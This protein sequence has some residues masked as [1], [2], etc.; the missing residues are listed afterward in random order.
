MRGHIVRRYKN[1]Y[2][3]VLNLGIDSSN[4]KYKQ[5]WISIKGTKKDAEKRLAELLH[6]IDT[7]TFIE[8]RK[9][10]L[11]EFLQRWL[12]DYVEPNLTPRTG[13][14]YESIMRKHIIPMLGNIKLTQFKPEH[15]QR[16]FAY[17]QAEGRCNGKGGLNSLTIRHHYMALHQALKTA[18]KWGLINRNPVD[19]IDPPRFERSVMHI[20]NEDDIQTFLEVA[21]TTSYYALFYL[22]LFTGM[23]RSELLAIR[24]CDV[25]MLLCQIYVS[26]ALHRLRDGS[27]FF[28][29]P[30]TAKGRRMISLSP[31]TVLVLQEHRHK[32]KLDRSMIGLQLT[33]N[34]LVFSKIDGTPI[35]PNVVTLAWIRL[36]K[37]TG[38]TGVRLHDARHTHASLMLKHGIHPKIVQ[39]RLGHSGIQITLD[40]YSHV[41]PGL[42]EA[43]AKRFDEILGGSNKDTSAVRIR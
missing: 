38:L 1:S 10:T 17:C 43:A 22:A 15:L 30:K 13:E 14:G 41:A 42:Q 24:W 9:T 26:R 25:D 3:I 27:I 34:D 33:D 8:P 37:R 19:A 29:V 32:Q 12:K 7:D 23:R 11:A 40:T 36:A 18:V 21:K 35:P 39:E 4:G 6:Q 16:Y 5:Q 2:T 31:S 20:M 28:G